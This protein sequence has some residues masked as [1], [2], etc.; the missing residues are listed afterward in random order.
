MIDILR[1]IEKE[2]ERWQ[3]GKGKKERERGVDHCLMSESATPSTLNVSV[4]DCLLRL[5]AQCRN[6]ATCC[7]TLGLRE[8][9]L[10][11]DR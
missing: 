9:D 8:K 7:K 6:D 11:T 3:Q 4:I 1:G 5:R 10:N 2:K